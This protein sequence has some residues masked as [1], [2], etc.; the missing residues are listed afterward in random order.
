VILTVTDDSGNTA[1]CEATVTVI[2]QVFPDA[3]CQNITV[4]L[5]ENG[6][7][8][9]TVQDVDGGSTDDSG[10]DTLSIDVASF[11]CSDIGENTVTLTVTNVDG[12]SDTCEAIVTVEDTIAPTVSCPEDQT[13][14]LEEGI[15]TFEVPDYFAT[16]EASAVDNCTDP[17]V[18][19]SQNPLPG[20]LLVVDIYTVTLCATDEFGNENCC[21]FQLTVDDALSVGD[22]I[23][24]SLSMYPNPARDQIFI[25]NPNGLP[26]DTIAIYDVRGRRVA[27]HKQHDVLNEMSMDISGISNGIYFVRMEGAFGSVIK[28]LIKR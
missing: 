26:I 14:V 4:Q 12:N 16:G 1:S 8:S 11:D 25:S 21:E 27:T 19:F 5:D 3:V 13:I 15:T 7:V 28:Q 23:G 6:A 22:A 20:T 9:I 2:D 24:S 17:V 18:Q 10:I